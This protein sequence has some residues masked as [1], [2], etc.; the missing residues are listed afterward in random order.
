MLAANLIDTLTR[1]VQEH[2]NLPVMNEYG[3]EVDDPEFNDDD[4]KCFL[5]TFDE[6]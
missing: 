1:L 2:G 4:G 3:H 5:V 6:S